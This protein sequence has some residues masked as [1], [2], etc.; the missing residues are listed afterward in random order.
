M[1][2]KFLLGSRKKQDAPGDTVRV[3]VRHLAPHPSPEPGSIEA[4][5]TGED[6]FLFDDEPGGAVRP[7]SYHLQT[8][9]HPDPEVASG[10]HKKLLSTR[11]DNG[12]DRHPGTAIV[13][14]E[15][16][17][18]VFSAEG[19]ALAGALLEASGVDDLLD[20]EPG[21]VA[22]ATGATGRTLPEAIAARSPTIRSPSARKKTAGGSGTPAPAGGGLLEEGS[23][24]PAAV[25]TAKPRGLFARLRSRKSG[26]NGTSPVSGPP[27]GKRRGFLAGL[28]GKKLRTDM[29][30]LLFD[31]GPLSEPSLEG[32]LK[33]VNVT[34][35]VDPPFQYIHI[36]FD[37]DEGSMLYQVREPELSD[38]EKFALSIVEQGF[39]KMISTNLD[40]IAGGDRSAYLKEKFISLLNIFGIQASSEQVE[41]M[42]FHLKKRYL[43]FSHMDSLM[44]DKYIE[45][46]SCNGPGMYIYVM[47]RIYG[48]MQTDVKFGEVELNNFVL[49]LA[50]VGG[51][52]ISLLQ[53]IR[54]VTLPDGSRANLTLG[55]E[56]TKKGSTFTVRKFR[57]SPISPIEMMEYGTI[58]AQQLAYLWIL[59]E[60]KR[61]ILVSGG[62]A[63]GKTT[64]LNVLCA[65]IPNEYKIVS[66]EDTAELNLMSPNWIQSV[67][68]TGFG[69][70]E[71]TIGA[72]GVS[73]ISRRSPGDISL[74]DLLVAALRQRPEFIIVGE[75]RGE[76]AFTLF[77]A[78]AVGHAA[79]GTIHAGSISELMA[80]IESNPMRVPR[81]LFSNLD[82]V[83]FPM[84]IMRGERSAR[85]V[86]NIVEILELDR[87]TQ[88]LITNTAFKW[89]PDL[90]TFR[91]QGRAF[92]FDKVH[93]TFG[94]SLDLLRQEMENRIRFLEW[95][96]RRGV[97]DY[98]QVI[99]MLRHYQRNKDLVLARMGE[100]GSLADLLSED[101]AG[102]TYIP[103]ADGAVLEE[104]EGL[105]EG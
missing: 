84:H 23:S 22:P 53:P 82:A 72:S 85:K 30:S 33:D 4:K 9:A 11:G 62:T 31:P 45:D 94:I 102:V 52:H 39:E 46:I 67:T 57:A 10:V 65:F 92:L 93:E 16:G 95:L 50:Q 97:R 91:F 26:A 56:V 42:F 98:P 58:D 71:T 37:P 66:I 79:L 18:P 20:D 6:D 63:T 51:R 68:R 1:S 21:S 76:E 12:E 15:E 35:P 87:D 83:I 96:R 103:G 32:S 86:A 70:A 49:K 105:L 100:D 101:Q 81:S 88:D 74:Y 55:G 60:Y 34:Y 24:R 61:S 41:R 14:G 73:G 80:R 64:M 59:M 38:D 28:F 99:R 2:K 13:P 5:I 44:K 90:D 78:I 40:L 19:S 47:H 69:A 77:Q 54:D 104:E 25:G 48:S 43:G 27:D 3:E 29:V 36:E 7:V 75:V 17:G 89:V 8:I